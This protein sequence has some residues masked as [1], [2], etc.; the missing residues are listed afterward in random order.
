MK[1]LHRLKKNEEFSA[2]FKKGKS[3]ADAKIVIYYKRKYSADPY[4]VG[5]SVGKKLGKAV[6]RNRIKRLLREVVRLNAE[7][8]PNGID[9]VLIARHGIIDQHY[10][11][12]E[13]SF[14]KLMKKC[15]LWQG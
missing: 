7:H 11:E 1:S 14:I 15:S 12:I 13:K 2:V 5:F 6:M 8:I 4:R 3:I 9:L 10:T